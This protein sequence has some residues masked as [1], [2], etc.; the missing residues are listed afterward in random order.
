MMGDRL[1]KALHHP[2]LQTAWAVLIMAALGALMH[3]LLRH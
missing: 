3:W 2:V 1:L